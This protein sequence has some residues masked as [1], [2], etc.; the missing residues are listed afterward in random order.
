[1]VPGKMHGFD[2]LIDL[3][4]A[5]LSVMYFK[6]KPRVARRAKATPATKVA[7][8]ES[9]TAN[10]KNEKAKTEKPRASARRTRASKTDEA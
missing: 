3:E 1:M 10:K 6:G 9:K 8:A 5:P 7:K 4:I 2:D